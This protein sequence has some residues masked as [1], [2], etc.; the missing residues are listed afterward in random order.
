M[1]KMKLVF[2]GVKVLHYSMKGGRKTKIT[3]SE[4]KTLSSFSNNPREKS[5]NL[6]QYQFSNYT[7]RYITL[8]RQINPSILL[9]LTFPFCRSLSALQKGSD[10]E[11]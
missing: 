6:F 5:S 11:E 3:T 10:D 9:K 8:V 2:D 7:L 1:N 4:V